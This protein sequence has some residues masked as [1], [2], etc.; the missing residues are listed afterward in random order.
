MSFD[1]VNV[2]DG[3]MKLS[4]DEFLSIPVD[5]VSAFFDLRHPNQVK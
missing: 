2:N 3:K 1:N 5:S 4:A